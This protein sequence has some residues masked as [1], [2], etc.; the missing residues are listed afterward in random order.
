MTNTHDIVKKTY[1]VTIVVA[2]FSLWNS[3]TSYMSSSES[4]PAS[5]DTFQRIRHIQQLHGVPG[6]S[7]N[8]GSNDENSFE[9]KRKFQKKS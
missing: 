1:Y 2:G 9:C 7:G 5:S 6:I 4:S 8:V 3:P